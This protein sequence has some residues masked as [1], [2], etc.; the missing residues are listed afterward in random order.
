MD[1]DRRGEWQTVAVLRGISA[2]RYASLG[3]WL[4]VTPPILFAWLA[5]IR[6]TNDYSSLRW[7]IAATGAIRGAV[8]VCGIAVLF[9]SRRE[10]R[11]GYTTLWSAGA[12]VP[13]VDART[14]LVLRA[15]GSPAATADE[16]R[17]ARR[18]VR[19][20]ERWRLLRGDGDP[21]HES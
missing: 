1:N 11:A 8:C 15:P 3:S 14:G 12:G 5:R 2:A 7:L 20:Y 10:R 9:R 17:E 4:S 19:D 16:K 21:A 6:W 18:R 13:T